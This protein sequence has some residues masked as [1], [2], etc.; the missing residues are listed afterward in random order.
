MPP[1]LTLHTE[2]LLQEA[3]PR[4]GW[5][6]RAV[7]SQ[8][9]PATRRLVRSHSDQ[10]RLEALLEQS[11]PAYPAGTE[12]LDYLLKTPFR[13]RPPNP[14]GSRFRRPFSPYGVFYAAEAIH[15]ALAEFAFH[16]F[17]FFFVSEGTEPPAQEAQLT[18]FS[19]GYRT[20]LGLDL[21]AGNLATHR[22]LWTDPTDYSAT[23]SLGETAAQ[24]GIGAVR[25]ES[26]RAPGTDDQGRG[27]G[28]NVGI[29][30]PA[31]F[32]PRHHCSP[33]AWYL[34]LGEQEANARRAFANPDEQLTFPKTVFQMPGPAG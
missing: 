20:S 16:R 23:Q 15:T 17:R 21:T 4:S 2:D 12:Q 27:A 33:Q 10:E 22:A 14:N 24:A 30:D 28:R 19:A 11:K 6:W 32:Q 31:V 18:V 29:L 3:A 9:Y 8:H 1:T 5:V 13:Y 34:Y 26:V 7:E 25:Y